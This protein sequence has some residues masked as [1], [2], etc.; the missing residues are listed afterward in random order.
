MAWAPVRGFQPASL[1]G[2]GPGKQRCGPSH[3]SATQIVYLLRFLRVLRGGSFDFTTEDAEDSGGEQVAKNL[4]LARRRVMIRATCR[5]RILPRLK[6]NSPCLDPKTVPLRTILPAVTSSR[7]RPWR[8][9][10]SWPAAWPSAAAPTPPGS[11]ILKVGLIGCG[12]RGTGAAGN[13]LNADPNAKLVAM[14]DAF[15]DRLEEQPERA[16]KKQYGD[17]VDVPTDHCFAGFDAYQKVLASGVDVVI[18]AEPP[19][20]RPQHLKAA[21]EAGKHVF[22]EKPVAVD[23]PG[24]RSVLATCEEAKKKNLS[25]VSGLCWRYHH[26]V[27]ETMQRVL[28][29]AIGDIVAIQETYLTGALW[30]RAAPAEVDRNGVPDAQ[31]VLLHLALRRPQRRAAR[32]QPGQGR[33]GHA[34]RA[35]G[36][37]PGAWAGARS[38]PT[39]KFGDI[40]DHHAVVY[41][42]A[43]GVRLYSYCRQQAGCY[44]DVSDIFIG[45]KGR[46]NIL[47]SYQIEGRRQATGNSRA[48]AATCTT[49]STRPCSPPIRSGKPINNGVYMARSTMLAILGRMVD[50]TGQVLTW[51]EAINSKQDLSPEPLRLGR[52][53][54][55]HARQ[56]RPLPGRHARRDAVRVKWKKRRSKVGRTERSEARRNS[57]KN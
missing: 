52:R 8:P 53:A 32:P 14:A 27:K 21:I 50:Y 6:G 13:A 26:G 5:Y 55:D 7:P 15:E 1:P 19:H 39:P 40:Y 43:N 35:A 11:D 18:L 54:A 51:D 12:G 57:P 31:L 49:S 45:T 30:H 29:G 46:A 9:A 22:C 42:Y 2:I 20:F 10:A 24:V 33:L 28:D 25:L 36:A 37:G 16:L 44:S 4:C 47:R 3:K 34:R 17:R 48:R 38:A 56:G 23:A 41:E